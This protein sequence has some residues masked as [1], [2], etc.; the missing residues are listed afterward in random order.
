MD[1][2]V[3]KLTQELVA[4]PSETIHTNTAIIN[5]LERWLASNQFSVECVSYID[6]NGEEKANLI[7]KRGVGSGGLGFFLTLGYRARRSAGM[8][9]VQ[10]GYRGW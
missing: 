1:D 9:P 7:A 4:I 10:C 2:R 6:V 5:H 8:G 3:I